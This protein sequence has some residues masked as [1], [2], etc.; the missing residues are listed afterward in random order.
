MPTDT[1]RIIYVYKRSLL[2]PNIALRMVLILVI[3]SSLLS[4]V[5]RFKDEPKDAFNQDAF[6]LNETWTPLLDNNLSLW[7]VWLGV[8]HTSVTGLPSS[9]YKDHN[10]HRQG[11]ASE[12]LGLDAD[13]KNVF[14]IV[15]ENS[16]TILVVTGEI[17]GGLTSR[18]SM[19]NYHLSM[20][21]KWGEKKW[22][23]R[24]DKKRDSGLL[25]HCKGPH[26]AF[27][28]VWKACHELQIQEKDFGDYIPLAGPRGDIRT[29]SNS[30]HQTYDPNGSQ[31]Q[32][33]TGYSHASSEPDYAN[34]EWNLVELYAFDTEA[35]FVINGVVV[36]HVKNSRD[37][38]NN[39]LRSGQ[40]QQQSE[41]AE[42]FF[43]DLK[44]RSISSFP[45]AILV[46]S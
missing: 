7:E 17:Y 8:P 18:F 25:F 14:S 12:A 37:A 22:A 2:V 41:G 13:I 16:E 5:A 35:I 4:C 26:G 43:K 40:I 32:T 38:Q 23:P 24:L 27:W 21:V 39:P 42:V 44:V 6:M 30:T 10:L 20:Q 29:N 36:M 15:Q 31:I 1:H 33:V 11:D 9:T 45:Q 28:R 3:T 46:E 19:E 34:G